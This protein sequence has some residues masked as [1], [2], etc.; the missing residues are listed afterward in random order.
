MFFFNGELFGYLIRNK[1]ILRCFVV[2]LISM[3]F[4]I[5]YHYIQNYMHLKILQL[6]CDFLKVWYKNDQ[7]KKIQKLGGVRGACS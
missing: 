6:L 3:Y 1:I 2:V 5:N 7:L 4:Y